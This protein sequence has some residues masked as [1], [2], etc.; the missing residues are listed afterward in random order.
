M[1]DINKIKANNTTYDVKDANV[2]HSSASAASGGTT[3]SLVTTGEKYNWNRTNYVLPGYK[4]RIV[5]KDFSSL[6]VT[7]AAGNVYVSANQTLTVATSSLANMTTLTEV[8]GTSYLTSGT[9]A[10]WVGVQSAYISGSNLVINYV[11]YRHTSNTLSNVRVRFL[12]IG[13]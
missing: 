10:T 12:V 11:V 7:T 8:I 5:T 1:A 13:T 3:L 6:A 9:T 2:P 4:V